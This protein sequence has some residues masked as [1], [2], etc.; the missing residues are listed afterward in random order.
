MDAVRAIAFHPMELCLA[1]GG[2]DYSVKIWRM[3]PSELSSGAASIINSDVEPQ[4]TYRGHTAPIT[5]LAV[6]ATKGLI[7][8]ASIDSTIHVWAIPPAALPPYAPYNPTRSWGV[9]V[10]HTDAVWDIAL[11]REDTVLVSCG[12]EG[13]VKVWSLTGPGA[14][15]LKL[16]WGIDGL[17]VSEGDKKEKEKEK[18]NGT[19]QDREEIG[20]TAVEPIKADLK[21]VAVA[22]QNSVVKLFGLE[23]GI[24]LGVLYIDSGSGKSLSIPLDSRILYV[25]FLIDDHL[26]VRGF[27]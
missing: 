25:P 19:S 24:V 18:E 23:S 9:L 5:R 2:D 1:T 6:S 3:S 8:S 10:G 27:R 15:S 12:A 13:L 17:D 26:F 7:Y 22:Y 4:I 11:T 14:G 16:S 20:A 21:K